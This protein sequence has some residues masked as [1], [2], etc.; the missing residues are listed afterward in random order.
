MTEKV[1]FLDNSAILKRYVYKIGSEFIRAQYNEVY[2]GNVLLSFNVWNIGEVIGV[3]DR[4]HRQKGITVEKLD[5]TS[6]TLGMKS[7]IR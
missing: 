6:F 3:F 4:T 2:L 7:F 1:V 5:V